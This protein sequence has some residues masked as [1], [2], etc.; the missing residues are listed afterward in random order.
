M[1]ILLFVQ[2]DVTEQNAPHC[3]SI[4]SA[5]HLPEGLLDHHTLRP[6]VEVKDKLAELMKNMGHVHMDCQDSEIRLLK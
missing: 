4:N 5:P 2:I 6:T 1:Q 3:I